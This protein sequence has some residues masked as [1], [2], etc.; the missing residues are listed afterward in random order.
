VSA[1]KV[2]DIEIIED[3]SMPPDTGFIPDW[4][5]KPLLSFA[6]LSA[7]DQKAALAAVSPTGP[8]ELCREWDRLDKDSRDVLLDYAKQLGVK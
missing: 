6:K 7:E 8:R 1:N 2:G 4:D 3:P 5:I